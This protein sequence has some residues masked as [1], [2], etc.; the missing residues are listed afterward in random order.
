MRY[1]N[2]AFVL[3]S[4]GYQWSMAQ[5]V[6]RLIVSGRETSVSAYPF[7]VA[8]L[9]CETDWG[10]RK[11]CAIFCS[12]SLIAPNLVLTAGHCVYDSDSP[13]GYPLS[14]TPLSNMYVML[15]SSDA[16]SDPAKVIKV[17]S[18]IN[19]GYAT[20]LR[21]PFDDDIGLVFLS[22]CVDLIPGRIET[23]KVAT[24]NNDA[25]I[26]STCTSVTT[27]GYGRHR[28]VSPVRAVREGRQERQGC[29]GKGVP[30]S[31]G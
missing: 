11:D 27:T 14:P 7:T 18:V 20:N 26:T 12:G 28:A 31:D 24:P 19:G 6:R 16:Q 4:F 8:L 30:A 22:E 29:G 21:F 25:Q 15:G 23:I 17:K 1:V 10:V 5:S 2:V 3:L 9:Y 13:F